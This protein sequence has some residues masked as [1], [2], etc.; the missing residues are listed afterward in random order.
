MHIT[1]YLRVCGVE[2]KI[3]AL[4]LTVQI[5]LI[6]NLCL[7]HYQLFLLRNSQ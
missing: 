1:Q 7:F 2:Y 4:L 3:D 6:I 5:M